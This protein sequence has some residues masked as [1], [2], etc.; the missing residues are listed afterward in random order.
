MTSDRNERLRRVRTVRR[1]LVAGAVTAALGVA[2]AY[3]MTT[4]TTSS[5]SGTGQTGTGQTGQTGTGQL[6]TGES[7]DGGSSQSLQ[8][9]QQAQPFGQPQPPQPGSG[10]APQALSSGS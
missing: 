8:Q 6:D 10:S 7:D 4:P 2:A 3:G 5:S 1:S 9:G